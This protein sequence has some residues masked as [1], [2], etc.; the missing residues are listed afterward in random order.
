MRDKLNVLLI[1]TDQQRGDCLGIEGHPVLMTPN[2]DSIAGQ[3]VRFS[4]AY[5]PCPTCIAARRSILSGQN[6][7]THKM[8]GYS[9]GVEWDPPMTLPQALKNNGYHTYFA[10][11]DMHQFPKRKRFGY[12]HMVISEDYINWASQRAPDTFLR[13]NND[14][15]HSSGILHN[16][17]TAR[18]WHL[19]EELHQ[20]NWAVN[21]ALKFLDNHDPSCPFFLTVSFNAPHPPLV[22]PA[23]YMERYLR[24][25]LPEPVLGDWAVPPD[26]GG[27]GQDVS[28]SEVDLKKEAL[29]SCR[30][31]YYGLINHVDDQIR[32]LLN[33]ITGIDQSNTIVIFTSDHGE[34]L[35]DHYLFRKSV[36][37]EASVRI[38]LL[39]QVP[40]SLGFKK[41]QVI[42][43]NACL[44]DIMPTVLELLGID[45][46]DTV[47]GK[48]L[49]PL[50][51]GEVSSWRSYVHIEHSP[52]HHTLT[53][54]KEKYIW[55][56][57]DGREQFF[58]LEKDPN[59]MRD[60]SK[61]KNEVK[62]ISWLRTMM[63]K[64]LESRPEGFSDGKRL[65]PG[66]EYPPVIGS[67]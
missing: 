10:G 50:I 44:T 49:V 43:N 63:I 45:I 7:S 26:N 20:T 18:P 59:E 62:R 56:T 52:I 39:I 41:G 12:D 1:I 9:E 5:T 25:D 51:R 16:D 6:P 34:M 32:R 57:K 64:E 47:E 42:D 36:P 30:A 17:W 11:R 66:R 65:I 46:P 61:D 54:G 55:F 14:I 40:D 31:G 67:C 22:P 4:K 2:M 19:S 29:L 21:E 48:S 13:K 37:Y 8:V 38:P 27:K 53:N 28:S 3:G 58:D 24:M 33:P 60:L 15:V 23:F 35:G